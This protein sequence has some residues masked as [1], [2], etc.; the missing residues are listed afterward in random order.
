M[1]ALTG[2]Q[3]KKLKALARNVIASELGIEKLID[4]E[5]E[6]VDP[7]YHKER[8]VFVTLNLDGRLRGC[9]GNTDP[10]YPLYE[11]VMKNAHDAAF[12]DPRFSPLEVDEF[13]DLNIEISVL[14]VPQKVKYSSA[15]D[16]L[17]KLRPGK[18]GVVIEKERNKATYLPQVWDD[19]KDKEDFLSS[20]CM[21][22]GLNPDEWMQGDCDVYK[23]E[24]EKF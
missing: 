7:F 21:K 10:I 9:I 15:K 3:K 5:N 18:D 19:I 16:L 20:L 23:Y 1:T 13:D 17:D 12:G 11:G 8:G 24:V 22:A 4:V 6:F 2:E 14:T